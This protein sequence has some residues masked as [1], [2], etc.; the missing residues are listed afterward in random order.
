MIENMIDTREAAR[1]LGITPQA[2]NRLCN[3]GTLPSL[4]L[5]SRR[6]FVKLKV[7]KFALD[8]ARERTTRRVLDSSDLEMNREGD[9]S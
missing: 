9:F 8:P 4:W 5:G 1:I 3:R 2:V 7:Q 6:V